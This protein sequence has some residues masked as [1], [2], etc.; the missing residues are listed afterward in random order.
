M[1]WH[2]PI[3][4]AQLIAEAREHKAAVIGPY[5]PHLDSA[6]KRAVEIDRLSGINGM[7]GRHAALADQLEAAGQEIVARAVERDSM[8]DSIVELQGARDALRVEAEWLRGVTARLKTRIRHLAHVGPCSLC[9]D[10][11]QD[12]RDLLEGK[13]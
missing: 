11:A 12:L 3:F 5:P 10:R 4:S 13:V 2:D 6:Q 9:G 1:I 8:R 7:I